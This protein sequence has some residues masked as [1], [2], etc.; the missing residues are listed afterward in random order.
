VDSSTAPGTGHTGAQF[1]GFISELINLSVLLFEFARGKY[2][3]KEPLT[4]QQNSFVPNE[5]HSSR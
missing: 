2:G 3:T 5:I 4:P 1:I